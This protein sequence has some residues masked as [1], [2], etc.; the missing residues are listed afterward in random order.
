VRLHGYR[1][2]DKLEP[3]AEVLAHHGE[4]LYTAFSTLTPGGLQVEPLPSRRD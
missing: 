3:I 2:R 4:Q 1:A